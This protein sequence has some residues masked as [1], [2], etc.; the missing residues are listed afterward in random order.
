MGACE[1][2]KNMTFPRLSSGNLVP[3][4]QLYILY[5][6]PEFRRGL[7]RAEEGTQVDS[8]RPNS[9]NSLSAQSAPAPYFMSI[10]KSR[11]FASSNGGLRMGIS[12]HVPFLSV[13]L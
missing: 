13:D 10:F 4:A 2:S 6:T 5:S 9:R 8:S 7:S 11:I 3:N 1:I 12:S